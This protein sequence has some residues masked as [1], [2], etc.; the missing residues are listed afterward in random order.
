M[1]R[2]DVTLS[3]QIETDDFYDKQE[4]IATQCI[5]PEP[6]RAMN[7]AH[8]NSKWCYIRANQTCA[9]AAEDD[10]VPLPASWFIDDVTHVGPSLSNANYITHNIH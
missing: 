10:I 3:I 2:Y 9:A 1:S 7:N 8:Y 5:A 4:A 6:A